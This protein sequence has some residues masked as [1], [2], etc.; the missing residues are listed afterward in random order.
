MADH[1]SDPVVLEMAVSVL[2]PSDVPVQLCLADGTQL[3]GWVIGHDESVI[4]VAGPAGWMRSGDQC[5][6]TVSDSHRAGYE[7]D[8]WVVGF[9]QV[10]LD[11]ETIRFAVAGVRRVKSRR[12][13]GR[14]PLRETAVIDMATDATDVVVV[15]VSTLGFAFTTTHTLEVGDELSVVLNVSGQVVPAA[16]QVANITQVDGEHVRVGCQ[17][18]EV[19]DVSRRLLEQ[20]ARDAETPTDRRSP[21]EQ[22]E[23]AVDDD[24]AAARSALIQRLRQNA[25]GQQAGSQQ[26][27]DRQL[28]MLYCRPCTRFTLHVKLSNNDAAYRCVSCDE[29]QREASAAA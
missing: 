20:L 18:L 28:T 21:P 8:C 29:D 7:I 12:A 14:V 16:A 19:S 2:P 11:R 1:F 23:A 6:M 3:E 5:T 10:D 4:T 26:I 17:F 9:A 27:E 25:Q 15:D 24:E 13:T 22:A